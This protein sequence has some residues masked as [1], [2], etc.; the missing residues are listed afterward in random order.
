MV[1]DRY[2]KLRGVEKKTSW[3]AQGPRYMVK[4]GKTGQ[5]LETCHE[6]VSITILLAL[7]YESIME[8]IADLKDRQR[9][10]LLESEHEIRWCNPC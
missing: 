7:A 4:S 5:E 9:P 8:I 2:K 3:K 6:R 10:W 1:R